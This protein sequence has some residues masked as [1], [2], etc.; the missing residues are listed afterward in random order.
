MTIL[1]SAFKSTPR[2]GNRSGRR[3]RNV[4]AYNIRGQFPRWKYCNP[5]GVV[6]GGEHVLSAD[7]VDDHQSACQLRR[8]F[9]AESVRRCWMSARHGECRSTTIQRVLFVLSFPG[10][11]AISQIFPVHATKATVRFHVLKSFIRPAGAQNSPGLSPAA[12][13][14]GQRQYLIDDLIDGLLAT[15]CR[16]PGSA[17]AG[18]RVEQ[19]QAIVD[20]RNVPHRRADLDAVFWSI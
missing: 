15:P 12:R 4:V 10:G 7:H 11:P 3:R 2:P 1:G 6:L 9:P 19:A 8:P 5:T 14:L 13:A 20:L 18:A 16:T 17:H